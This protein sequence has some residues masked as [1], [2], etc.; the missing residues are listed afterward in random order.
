MSRL[1]L[2]RFLGVPADADDA[3]VLGLESAATAIPAA[4]DAARAARIDQVRRHPA[5][6]GP[7]GDL[8]VARIT[9]AASRLR[10]R[11]RRPSEA[12]ASPKSPAS[13]AAPTPQPSPAPTPAASSSGPLPVEPIEPA[14][15]SNASSARPAALAAR[16]SARSPGSVI[17]RGD[18]GIA[19]PPDATF[20]PDSLPALTAFDHAVLGALVG[21]G[22]WNKRSRA[23]IVALA[24]THEV[25]P[26]GLMN[27]VSGL[28]AYA[29]AGGRPGEVADIA[30]DF[31]ALAGPASGAAGPAIGGEIDLGPEFDFQ[32]ET[33]E[34]QWDES[35]PLRRPT[36]QPIPSAAER[37]ADDAAEIL[38]RVM[39]ELS[40]PSPFEIMKLSMIVL[41]PL[42]LLGVVVARSM[43][44]P[45]TEAPADGATGQIAGGSS[46]AGSGTLGGPTEVGSLTDAGAIE[47]VQRGGTPVF[48]R[49]PLMVGAPAPQVDARSRSDF[50]PLAARIETEVTRR[51]QVA[52]PI[53][54][55]TVFR[56]AAT[57][58][59][60]ALGWPRA[61]V[62]D[63]RTV[64][65]AAVAAIQ[66]AGDRPAVLE[67]L[68]AELRPPGLP[69]GT[70]PNG[71][72]AASAGAWRTAVLGAV[73][74][75]PFTPA[76]VSRV[77]REILASV[78]PPAEDPGR[79]VRLPLPATAGARPAAYAW[80][81]GASG[82]LVEEAA[83]ADEWERW[84]DAL[85]AIAAT[86]TDRAGRDA[87][88]ASA[89]E[90]LLRR[91]TDLTVE[92]GAGLLGRLL[93]EVSVPFDA[94]V[95]GLVLAAI[96]DGSIA[97]LDDTRA[98]TSILS[99]RRDLPW[100]RASHIVPDVAT[101]ATRSRFAGIIESAWPESVVA[102]A[103]GAG[104]PL[105]VDPEV[106]LRWRDLRI[107]LD[108]RRDPVNP[109]DFLSDAAIAGGL[110]EAAHLLAAGRLDEAEAALDG[111]ESALAEPPVRPDLR[112]AFGPAFGAIRGPGQWAADWERSRGRGEN[113]LNLLQALRTE[114]AFDLA[115][116][117]ARVFARVIAATP[118][119]RVRDLAESVLLEKFR[120]GTNVAIAL[121]D[122]LAEARFDAGLVDVVARYTG[123]TIVGG[124]AD[125]TFAACRL[126]MI[127][128]VSELLAEPGDGPD[129]GEGRFSDVVGQVAEGL[130]R[131]TAA[132]RG[133]RELD[134]SIRRPDQAVAGLTDAWLKAASVRVALR[135]VPAAIEVVTER[136]RV[137]QRIATGAMQTAV[138]ELVTSLDAAAFVAAS[139]Q[140]GRADRLTEILRD[141]SDA[142]ARAK[143]A[144]EQWQVTERAILAVWALRFGLDARP[145]G[146][147]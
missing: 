116:E 37:A 26:P 15:R 98:L 45:V 23:R 16:D 122:A 91:N 135:P 6:P 69:T 100:F 126:A 71:V 143:T 44:P 10:G 90:G 133:D 20:D 36:G 43:S 18:A 139:E 77:C 107:A 136:R 14:P 85:D 24:G 27:V 50:A 89:I 4:I 30:P 63:A 123:R 54:D 92:P 106:L 142:R 49:I 46:G 52:A 17:A 55:A 8:V 21:H 75:D 128:Y 129:D 103:S 145:G 134:L 62:S 108:D 38:R 120:G 32:A 3:A 31:A 97:T 141:A 22:G 99:L 96:A 132:M 39:P 59:E 125:E 53:E 112:P 51:L 13:A 61:Q 78:V 76:E 67:R 79:V 117:D 138:V 144:G 64:R 19:S 102:V 9:L 7:D 95:R 140:P 105:P 81:A 65:A 11:S 72:P 119:R 80:L 28:A 88:I 40:S 48:A 84:F 73:I 146:I 109:I 56:W 47:I 94:T 29:R 5:G 87:V 68:A 124:D 12:A 147:R 83:G 58:D 33:P 35:A 34:V 131:R 115:P 137:R 41:L 127:E 113:A 110:A 86:T 93:D 66:T 111:V 118:T 1:P 82:R 130:V 121:M 2:E 101:S 114:A 42:I 57:N 25:P 70:T 104:R 74:V 60:A